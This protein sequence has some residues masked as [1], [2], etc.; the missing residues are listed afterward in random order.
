[1][2]YFRLVLCLMLFCG[3]PRSPDGDRRKS[4]EP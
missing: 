4:P 3:R 2:S 1:M